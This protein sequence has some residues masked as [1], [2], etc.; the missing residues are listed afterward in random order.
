MTSYKLYDL[1]HDMVAFERG[2]NFLTKILP[3]NTQYYIPY[4]LIR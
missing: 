2:E 1:K 3:E 4:L